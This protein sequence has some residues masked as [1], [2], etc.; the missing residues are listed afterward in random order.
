MVFFKMKNVFLLLFLICNLG[1]SYSQNYFEGAIHFEL[2]YK[3]KDNRIDK[4]DLIREM[5]D[6]ITAFIKEDKFILLNNSKGRLGK[7][8]T[9]FH[10]KQGVCYVDYENL[11]TIMKYDLNKTLGKL[12]RFKRDQKNTTY[13]L[14]K[15]C[16]SIFIE[17]GINISNSSSKKKSSKYFFNKGELKL[18]PKY[19]DKYKINFYDLYASQSGSIPLRIDVEYSSLYSYSQEA[20]AIIK[21]EYP[22]STFAIDSSKIIR[23]SNSVFY[24]N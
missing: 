8:K 24:K 20:Y 19:Y 21:H 17:Q 18:N 15:L 9:I 12:L 7:R 1:F 14:G 16:E 5:G 11:D 10:L 3:I 22:D 4:N 13:V 2:N 23:K 6:S